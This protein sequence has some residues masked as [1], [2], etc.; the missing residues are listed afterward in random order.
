MKLT[1]RTQY[2]CLSHP[3]VSLCCSPLWLTVTWGNNKSHQPTE[4]SPLVVGSGSKGLTLTAR[5]G[6]FPPDQ[7]SVRPHHISYLIWPCHC[8]AQ[9]LKQPEPRPLRS[10]VSPC[11]GKPRLPLL[12]SLLKGLWGFYQGKPST[13]QQ[14][15][16]RAALVI[17]LKSLPLLTQVPSSSHPTSSG[18]SHPHC[19]VSS[20]TAGGLAF[21][22]SQQ[23][24]YYSLKARLSAQIRHNNRRKKDNNPLLS[25]SYTPRTLPSYL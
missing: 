16:S 25:S 22:L 7:A 12:S 8:E 9:S 24:I 1:P 10:R 19:H 2:V 14:V 13:I 6:A 15:S 23:Y 4:G 20:P 18:I 3:N 17:V 11:L 21:L 5:W